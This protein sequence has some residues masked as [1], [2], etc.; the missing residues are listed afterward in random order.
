MTER[1]Q[2]Q[3]GD[4]EGLEKMKKGKDLRVSVSLALYS[5]KFIV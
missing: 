5:P 3:V 1:R 2:I 4:R